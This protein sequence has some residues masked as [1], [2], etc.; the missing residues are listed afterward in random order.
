MKRVAS[1]SAI[2]L[3]S[4]FL[5]GIVTEAAAEE[6]TYVL[7]AAKWKARQTAA[8]QAAG[9]EVIFGH[10]RSG[11]GV[12]TSGAPDF[13]DR[14]L[15]S[16]AFT[17]ATVDFKVQWQQPGEFV[18][19]ATVT[20]GDET[21][22]GFQWNM[23]TIDAEGAWNEGYDGTGARVAVIDGG[24][25]DIHADLTDQIDKGCST[26]FVPGEP[27]NND[28]GTFWH[29]THVAGIVAAADNTFGVIGVAPGATI[30]A[31]KSLHSGSGSFGQVIG[32]ILFASDPSSF[33]GFESC[34]RADII[35]MSLGAV[36]PRHLYGRLVGAMAKAVNFAASKGVLVISAAGN[37]G[38][39][40][41]QLWDYTF[42]P[43]ESGSGLAISATGPVGFAY[44]GD[45]YRRFASYSNYGESL[46]TLAAP[47]GDDTLY[48]ADPL[49]FFDMVLSTCK[50]TSTPPT[51]SFCF[52]DGTSMAAPHAAGVA[53]LIMQA[54]P[55]ISLGALKTKLKN[56]ADDE[57]KKGFD[58]F[59]GHGF[60][61]AY[62]AVTK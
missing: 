18:E 24:I 41:G 7:T 58:E 8:V 2:V 40:L 37:N 3:A 34:E 62:R 10:R 21:F 44:G 57:G 39:D 52:A 17:S 28:T 33:P 55:G 35:N 53:A 42:L 32:G 15:A 49:W 43:A 22:Y 60:V 31:I 38:L 20:P 29:A 46:V 23:W 9:G 50:G 12:A 30:M 47:G 16:G 56:T 51:Y 48:P 59:Y 61:N 27:Y 25:Y 19:H 1:I 11:L 26:S 5:M 4:A 14:V 13:L 45:E 36:L 54:N 6:S